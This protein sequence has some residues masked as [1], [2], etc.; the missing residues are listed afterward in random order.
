MAG[1][2]VIIMKICRNQIK[3]NNLKNRFFFSTF[4]CIS[5]IDINGRLLFFLKD[6]PQSLRNSEIIDPEKGIYLNF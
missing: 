4:Y 2:A 5:E 1:I 3:Y 6:K